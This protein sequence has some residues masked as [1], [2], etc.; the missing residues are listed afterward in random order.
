[1][2]T[3][4]LQQV[5][6]TGLKQAA[7][8]GLEKS[9]AQTS[10]AEGDVARF[11]EGLRAGDQPTPEAA[12]VSSVQTTGP[13]SPGGLGDAI[14]QG[15]DKMRHGRAQQMENISALADK[16]NMTTKDMFKL[17]FELAQLTLQQDLTVKAADKS[18]QAVQTLFKNQ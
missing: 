3:I 5:V 2:D 18:N 12:N 15:L 6:E 16:D 11:Q 1:M 7:D 8:Q 10:P 13:S 14:L 4:G 17:Q 9:A